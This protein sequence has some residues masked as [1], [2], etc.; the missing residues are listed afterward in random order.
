VIYRGESPAFL[1]GGGARAF[2]NWIVKGHMEYNNIFL[3]IIG[4]RKMCP[5]PLP[6]P[7]KKTP[8]LISQDFI[9]FY[10]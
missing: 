5:L 8:L 1:F 6:P 3:H 4:G 10:F 9:K 2:N 7:K